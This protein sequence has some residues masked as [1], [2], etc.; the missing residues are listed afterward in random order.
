M[1]GGTSPTQP[2]LEQLIAEIIAKWHGDQLDRRPLAK[3]LA[4]KL[5]PHLKEPAA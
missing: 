3:V 5:Q 2:D 1:S 4:E